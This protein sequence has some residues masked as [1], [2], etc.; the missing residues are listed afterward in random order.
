M[1]IPNTTYY[2]SLVTTNP[3]RKEWG[4]DASGMVQAPMD[5]GLGLPPGPDYPAAL[6]PYLH[7][8]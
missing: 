7:S 2:E 3:V 8:I 4:I 6:R 5:H 1:A